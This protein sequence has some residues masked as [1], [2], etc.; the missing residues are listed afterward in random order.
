MKDKE[1]IIKTYNS[2]NV[3][4]L[5]KELNT[6]RVLAK[7]LINRGYDSVESA[8]V[9]LK[10]DLD[11]FHSPFLMNGIEKGANLLLDAVKEHKKILI[12]GDYDV[13]GVTSVTVLLKYIISIGGLC[14]YY[15]PRRDDDGYG[16][17]DRVINSYIEKGIKL[18]ITVDSGITAI[19]EIKNAKE[20]GIDVI[21]TDHH[22]CRDILPEADAV[23]NPKRQDCNYPFEELAGVGVVFKF[24]CAVEMLISGCTHLQAVTKLIKQYSEFVAIGT[25]AD[26]M[27]ISDENRLIVSRG[28]TAIEKTDNKGLSALTEESGIISMSAKKKKISSATVGFILAPRINAAGRMENSKIAVDL[29][30]TDSREE[31]AR[32]A[33][34]LGE[35]NKERQMSENESLNSAL[36]KIHTQCDLKNDKVIVLEDDNWHHGIIGIVSSRITERFN[37]PSILISFKNE[38]PGSDPDIG[39]GSARSIKGMN[40]VRSL[41]SCS[42]LLQKYGGH[43]LAA[44]LSIK[45]SDLPEFRKRINE[46]AK[47]AFENVSL[48]KTLDIDCEL[49]PEE[50]T[51]KLANEISR[52]EPFGLANP[53]PVF[54]TKGFRILSV[55]PIGDGKHTKIMLEKNSQTVVALLFGVPT[56]TFTYLEGDLVDIA[57]NID[58][59]NFRNQQSVQMI[60]RD[61]RPSKPERDMITQSISLYNCLVSDNDYKVSSRD[62]PT[63]SE[64]AQIYTTLRE[65]L[66]TLEKTYDTYEV[67]VPYLVK[68]SALKYNET[69]PLHKA[70]IILDVLMET[71][72]IETE[73]I[74]NTLYRTVK[75]SS[76]NV[77]KG[78]VILENAPTIRKLF[79]KLDT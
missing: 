37:L 17:N 21:V 79:T 40:L 76:K 12:W 65:R 78:K 51:V 77:P 10:K 11:A 32:L 55:I 44:G 59:N 66:G 13:D 25:I 9:F 38:I 48:V 15:I 72:L 14:E 50:F 64:F 19:N 47:K 63:R 30:M 8:Q 52:L 56:A 5:S 23:I 24:I 3:T 31:A 62:I 41:S 42:D 73:D 54:A 4:R 68:L 61:I 49:A 43:E 22:E 18:L 71:E 70:L 58:V 26:V 67:Y 53:V 45:R 33:V 60:V 69:I 74:Y 16:L 34:R 57:Y 35:I 6:S 75:I 2:I 1:W 7:L 28:L 20:K 27:P 39:K 46:Y 36:E 29:F